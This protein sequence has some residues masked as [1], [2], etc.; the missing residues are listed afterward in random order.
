MVFVAFGGYTYTNIEDLVYRIIVYSSNSN[1]PARTLI[2]LYN[3]DNISKKLVKSGS[4]IDLIEP[5]IEFYTRSIFVN[6]YYGFAMEDDFFFMGDN[7]EAESYN[8]TDYG[9]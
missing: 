4:I 1:N 3:N 5:F 2:P 7:V 6:C 8:H 9:I